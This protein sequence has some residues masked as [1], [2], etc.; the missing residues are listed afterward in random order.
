[1]P[2]MISTLLHAVDLTAETLEIFH[3]L[4][5]LITFI[6]SHI[7]AMSRGLITIQR[8][9]FGEN[10][11]PQ[12]ILINDVFKYSDIAENIILSYDYGSRGLTN[13]SFTCKKN[14]RATF[15]MFFKSNDNECG[16]EKVKVPVEKRLLKN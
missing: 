2:T 3:I 16:G 6:D 4:S 5:G 11:C 7:A 12:E 1:M 15:A 9:E 14:G 13:H 10:T 8:V